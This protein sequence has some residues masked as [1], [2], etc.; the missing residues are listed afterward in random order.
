MGD[1]TLPAI[2]RSLNDPGLETVSMLFEAVGRLRMALNHP[3]LRAVARLSM[4]AHI[5]DELGPG[6]YPQGFTAPARAGTAEQLAGQLRHHPGPATGVLERA[7]GEP[8]RVKNKTAVTRAPCD[9][10][11]LRLPLRRGDEIL[12]RACDLIPLS[13]VPCARVRL[14]VVRQ[15]L[16][17]DIA[18]GLDS[19]LPFGTLCGGRLARRGRAAEVTAD[20]GVASTALLL[21]DG[22]LAGY[23]AEEVTAGF[24]GH[25]AVR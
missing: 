19:D 11:R 8:L 25:V 22:Q 24:C 15:L 6:L 7:A 17:E 20:G 12:D 21:L 5:L 9:A 18:A 10:D 3:D 23:A 13:G 1:D 16:P 4:A 14:T 2:A